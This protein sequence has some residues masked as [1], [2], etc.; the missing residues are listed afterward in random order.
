MNKKLLLFAIFLISIKS[1]S[2]E[3]RKP[4]YGEIYDELGVLSGTHIINITTKNAT[5]SNENGEFRIPVKVGD[6]LKITSI[7][8]K[9]LFITSSEKH[10]SIAKNRFKMTRDIVELDEIKVKSH[11]LT[12]SLALDFKRIPKDKK[13]VALANTMDFSNINM[14]AKTRD[15]YVDKRVR[16]HIVQTDPVSA[17]AGAGSSVGVPFGSSKKL[18]ALRRELNFKESFPSKLLNEFGEGFFFQKLKIPVENYTQ[19]ITYCSYLNIEKL[20]Q[21]NKKLEVIQILR[22]ENINFLKSIK[23]E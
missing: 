5:Y 22:K 6:T 18:W 3:D 14:K 8:Y 12:G 23:K 9:T 16:P 4:F 7:G 1:V 21:E 17:N 2:Q 11:N 13:A 19:F 15:D 10:L 20:Y